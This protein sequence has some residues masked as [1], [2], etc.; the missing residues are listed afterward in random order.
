ML[1]KKEWEE[2]K[3][4]YMFLFGM[5]VL[6]IIIETTLLAMLG[7]TFLFLTV[8]QMILDLILMSGMLALGVYSYIKQ[9]S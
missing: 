9:R 3:L 5:F 8:S 2:K 4:T 6:V 1:R 7:S